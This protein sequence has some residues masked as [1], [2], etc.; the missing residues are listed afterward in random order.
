MAE[1]SSSVKIHLVP[2]FHYDLAYLMSF[3]EY[4]PRLKHIFTE[5]L[6]I[7]EKNPEYTYMFEQALLVKL[8]RMLCPEHF[9]ILRKL[10]SY[11]RIEVTGP[12]I[13]TDNNIPSGESLV[14]NL[15][16]AKKT[17]EKIGGETKTAWLG[18]VFG[19]NA[20]TPQIAKLCGYEYLQFSRG[21]SQ[22]D[23]KP[24]F[25]WEALDGTR[26][27]TCC[28]GYGG[29]QFTQNVEENLKN[30]RMMVESLS[31]SSTAGE[32][33][34]PSG[35][36]WAVPAQNAPETV[37]R[38]NQE[39]TSKICFS[40][41]SK[42]FKSVA[43][44]AVGLQ[45]V[46]G[47]MNPVMRGTYSSRIRLK[48]RNRE[49]E[50]LLITAEK[51]STICSLMG[52]EYPC[53]KLEEAWEKVLLNQ[54]HDVICGSCVDPAFE[55]ALQWYAES[56]R[57]ASS[58][59]GESLEF[60]SERI[61]TGKGKGRPVLVFN[62]LGFDRRDI[63]R[64]RL[65]FVK[66]GVKTVRVFD[67]EGKQV[68]V[69]LAEKKYYGE[70][71]PPHLPVSG[72]VEFREEPTETVY[73]R[74]EKGF[75]GEVEAGG[76]REAVVMFIAEVPALG[77]RVYRL[78]ETCEE[79]EYS[80]S[81]SVSGKTLENS[82]YR[83]VFNED[84][85]IRSI[86]DK[87]TGL[88]YVDPEK[89]F[90]NNLILQI[91]RGDLYTV[92]PMLDPR[93]PLPT[94]VREKL[95]EIAREF[96]IEDLKLWDYVESRNMPVKI[97]VLEEGPVRATV[98]VSGVL[99]FW[100]GISI[101]FTQLIHLYDGLRRI[102]FETRLKPSGKQY[103]VRV[104]FPTSIRNGTIRHEIPFGHVERPEGEYPAQSWIDYSDCEKGLCVVNCGLPGNNVV[105]NVATISLLRS[106]AFEYK[107]VSEKGFEEKIQH[108]FKYSL[109]PFKKN[110]P[111]YMPWN[112]AAEA[113]NMLIAK[114][115]SRGNG[116]LPPKHSFFRVEPG[117]VV[118]SSLT[119]DGEHTLV[120]VYEAKGSK[121]S[122]RILTTL[123]F[124]QAVE[125]DCLNRET[126]RGVET[127]GGTVRLEMNN[128][129]IKTV[130]L[131]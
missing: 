30:I 105:D 5:V 113:N 12:Y 34:L 27:L 58:I 60:L 46:K 94:Q 101:A 31:G 85:T 126:G 72:R 26:L 108:S 99:R 86:V 112:H 51:L 78:Q 76:L 38:W 114:T 45:V 7:M 62:P 33:L 80:T 49:I 36:D 65:T 24:V 97:E 25:L 9:E 127:Q 82:F 84:G 79:Q 22:R 100:V 53:E 93:D 10:V 54:F 111:G 75:S 16:L 67:D 95:A 74:V 73:T 117:S 47:D 120:R 123:P 3:E 37:R 70:A 56:E 87:E 88:E 122:C 15:A 115:V 52:A 8:F 128:F 4:F 125:V 130:R 90:A 64:L 59:I 23:V 2:T 71:P 77:Y 107:G 42:F 68:P 124:K 32:V 131:F 104:C 43:G 48:I 110:D 102:D 19:Q 13:Q 96:H 44:K 121:T 129:E 89:P 14:R 81:L 29:V 109:I 63:V 91:D 21:L 116:P 103:R 1:S 39:N 106:V 11:G 61:D 28:G 17:I 118:L 41:A 69:Q 83:I 98:R 20:Q 55:Q 92:M 50:N 66:P 6:N 57:V 35:G 119:R 40:S 18:D